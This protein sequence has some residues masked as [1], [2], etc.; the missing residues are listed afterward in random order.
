[1][2]VHLS[3]LLAALHVDALGGKL[4]K[5][6]GEELTTRFVVPVTSMEQLKA[7]PFLDGVS[8]R[9][10]RASAPRRSPRRW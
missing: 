3:T 9:S 4:L 6:E 10:A 1:M 7:D 5:M 2:N 8:S